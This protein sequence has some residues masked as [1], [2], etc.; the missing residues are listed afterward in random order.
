M[1]WS[2][3]RTAMMQMHH[4][5]SSGCRG[6]KSRQGVPDNFP[7]RIRIRT[8]NSAHPQARMIEAPGEMAS[9]A[10]LAAIHSHLRARAEE[11][12]AADPADVPR[13][14][15]II[16]RMAIDAR[17]VENVKFVECADG[18]RGVWVL[19]EGADPDVRIVYCHGCSFMAGSLKLYAGLVSRLAV[20]ANA[21]LFFVDYRLAPEH[22]FPA[23]HEDCLEAFIWSHTHGPQVS[24]RAQAC[25][26][27]GDSCGGGLALSTA[28][29]ASR[30]G[31]GVESVVLLSPFVDLTVSG[32][33]S[34]QER[35]P[36][37]TADMARACAPMY[38]PGLNPEDP[39]LS[40][41]FANL[42]GLAPIQIQGSASDPLRDD[43]LR[44]AQR[45]HRAG[46]RTELHVWGGLPHAWY[47]FPGQL[48]EARRGIGLAG[49]FLHPR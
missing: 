45:A 12:A 18:P 29:A 17:P 47:L 42:S 32:E 31:A 38:A 35:D 24:R 46:V 28:L 2:R 20:A 9:A 41:L 10:A 22:A 48:P 39:R 6:L 14:R 34:L 19:P 4:A 36:L 23:A 25:F 8:R 7:G 40:P 26:L 5:D 13:I 3:R 44:L 33:S 1:L 37:L 16:D 30:A 49:E 27:A 21:A 15:A 11:L 43:A